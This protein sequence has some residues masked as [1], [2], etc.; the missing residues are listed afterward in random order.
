MSGSV[1]KISGEM[2]WTSQDAVEQTPIHMKGVLDT[3]G[4]GLMNCLIV[5]DLPGP[6]VLQ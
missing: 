2:A 1:C 6:L 3:S 4:L 5:L